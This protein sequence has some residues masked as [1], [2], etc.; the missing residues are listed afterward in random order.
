MDPFLKAMKEDSKV[1]LYILPILG[2]NKSSFNNFVGSYVSRDATFVRVDWGIETGRPH[3][4][5]IAIPD[6]W[7]PD[8][9][10]IIAGKYSE[11]SESAKSM[12][13]TY[14]GMAYR[15]QDHDGYELFTD[16]RLMVLDKE[17]ALRQKW[18]EVTGETIA[19]GAELMS[20][21]EESDVIDIGYGTAAALQ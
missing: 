4:H 17:P 13:R 8:V 7:Q 2:F 19:E 20:P 18:E 10:L 9:K 16:Y 14:S 15:R 5:F 21:P 12:I 3:R 6:L 1:T 11:I